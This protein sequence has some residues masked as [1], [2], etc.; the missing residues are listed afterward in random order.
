MISYHVGEAIFGL[1]VAVFGY[2]GKKSQDRIELLVNGRMDAA[3]ARITELEAK[4]KEHD[5]PIPP[6]APSVAPAA[7]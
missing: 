4:L 3:L 2:R 7:V 5:V 1:L 6:G